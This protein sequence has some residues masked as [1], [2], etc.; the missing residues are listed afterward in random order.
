MAIRVDGKRPTGHGMRG[1]MKLAEGRGQGQPGPDEALK[2][3]LQVYAEEFAQLFTLLKSAFRSWLEV[4]GH[5]R[6]RGVRAE[7]LYQA[8]GATY[9]CSGLLVEEGLP[10]ESRKVVAGRLHQLL[11]QALAI[12]GEYRL[13]PGAVSKY[14]VGLAALLREEVQSLG[15]EYG[16]EVEVET[17]PVRS[18]VMNEK[19][20]R[21]SVREALRS[22]ALNPYTQRVTL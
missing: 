18:S 2:E 17:V 19:V 15:S 3:Q 22:A 10:I 7:T 9:T 11:K 8:L 4:E 21:L 6:S 1:E 16:W 14:D 13:E 5:L 20:A 12:L